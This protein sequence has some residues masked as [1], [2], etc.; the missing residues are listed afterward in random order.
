MMSDC[1]SL[2]KDALGLPPTVLAKTVFLQTV[3]RTGLE[4]DKINARDLC[5]GNSAIFGERGSE[6]R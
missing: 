3:E 6:V 2:S 1:E 5:D 4:R